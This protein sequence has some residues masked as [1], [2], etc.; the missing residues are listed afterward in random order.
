MAISSSFFSTLMTS[1]N[2]EK[3]EEYINKNK[4]LFNWMLLLAIIIATIFTFFANKIIYILYG[5]SFTESVFVLQ[6]QIWTLIPIFLGVASFPYFA[7]E[8]LQKISLYKSILGL[9]LNIILNYFFIP[10]F[11]VVGA[12]Y[13][14][15]ISQFFTSIISNVLFNK[16]K[17]VFTYQMSSFKSIFLFKFNDF[18]I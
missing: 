14:T 9:I 1:V 5:N 4:L 18:K 7:I 6:V 12:A 10:Y 13:S 3:K 2:N 17:T 15:L 16:T 11:G 8:N